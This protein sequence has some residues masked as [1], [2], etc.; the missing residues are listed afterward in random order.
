[1]T[2]ARTQPRPRARRRT[3][4][5]VAPAALLVALAC[6][7]SVWP[8]AA[9]YGTTLADYRVRVHECALAL[10][11]LAGY[12]E[13]ATGI[14]RA[15]N[16]AGTVAGVRAQLP[17]REQVQLAGR[18]VEV[19]NSWLHEALD[20]Y[21]QERQRNAGEA[22]DS[23]AHLAERLDALSER[24]AELEEAMRAGTPRDKEAEK[25][26]LAAILRR[27]EFNQTPEGQNALT[28]LR[29]LLA[30]WIRDLFPGAR[31]WTPSASPGLTTAAQVIIYALAGL[32]VALVLWKFGPRAWRRARLLR[33]TPEEEGP[34]VVLGEVLRADEGAAE[35]LA[36]AES[37][38]RA[39]DLRGAIRRAYLALLCELGDRG[40]IGL[41]R[42]KTNRDYLEAVRRA[43]A[44]LY[45]EVRPLTHGFERHWY[46]SAP[47]TEQ[48][49]EDFRAGYR[50]ALRHR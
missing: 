19:D 29:E 40:V 32:V 16:E 22:A 9:G 45:R 41:A 44:D 6:L 18:Y 37:L 11:S 23:L 5:A 7:S 49:W 2:F 36:Q 17:P 21:E 50:Q 25:G 35:L 15:D 14:E 8:A 31:G 1:M 39:G 26:R 48:D 24:L 46:G 43:R 10:D 30:K 47:A 28:R 42:H 20:A 38:A 4:T 13:H 3:A 27:P 33:V 34:R 12:D